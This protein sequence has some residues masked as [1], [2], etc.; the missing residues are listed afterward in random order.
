MKRTH[1]FGFVLVANFVIPLHFSFVGHVVLQNCDADIAEA[2][3][4]AE[5]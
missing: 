5:D 4:L 3:N 1:G 2:I